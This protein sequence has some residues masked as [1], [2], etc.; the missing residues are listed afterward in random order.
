MKK[1]TIIVMAFFFLIAAQVFSQS[2]MSEADGYWDKRGEV[3]ETSTLLADS[4]NIDM[5]IS[6]YKKIAETATGAEKEEAIWKQIRA[7]YYKGKY[8]TNDKELKKKIYDF[9]KKIGE[10]NLATYPDSPGLNLF[11]AI[12]WGVWGEE[13]GILAAAKKGVA[14]KIKEL[15]EKTIA[16]D[17]EFDE[18]GGYRV[19]GRVYFKAPKIWPILRWPSKKEAVKILKKSLEIAPTNLD[20][21]QFYAEALYSQNQK[22]EAIGIMKEIL[23]TTE[24]VGGI[25]E[26]AVIKKEVEATLKEWEKK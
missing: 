12:V 17:P 19:L 3:F 25:A 11:L 26:D 2:L 24:V 8:T 10:A 22:E 9:G 23:A 20:S 1:M 16:L 14:G 21:K 7:Y 15:C 5:A 13:Y 4:T 18:A 6:L